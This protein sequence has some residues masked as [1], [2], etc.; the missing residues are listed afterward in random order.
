MKIKRNSI[1]ANKRSVKSNK[2]NKR[3]AITAADGLNGMVIITSGKAYVEVDEDDYEQGEG[4]FVNGW[5]FEIG[6][7][8]GTAQELIDDIFEREPIF[9][10]D[11]NNYVVL[12]GSLQTDV[13]V[14]EFNDIP[15]AEEVEAWKRG[16]I[17]LYVAHLW[18][19]LEV[20]MA[21]HQMT[22]EEA[23]AFGFVVY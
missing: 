3:R 9:F 10:N 17:Q 23:E 19:N 12:D 6:T 5:D 21:S 4:A 18:L 16:E 11:I 15:T 1:K 7:Q 8:F 22:E 13:T 2:N 20:G 14:N